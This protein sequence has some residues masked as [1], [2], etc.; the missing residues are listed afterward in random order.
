MVDMEAL[1]SQG[2]RQTGG[3]QGAGTEPFTNL[4][5]QMNLSRNCMILIVVLL[6]LILFKDEIMKSSV[7]KS[8]S[9]SLK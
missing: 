1:L 6:A 7:V 2:E 4:F 5:P 3:Q 9:K 8:I